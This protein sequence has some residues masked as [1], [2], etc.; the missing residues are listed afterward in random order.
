[1]DRLGEQVD[2]LKRVERISEALFALADGDNYWG[3]RI[4]GHGERA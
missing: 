2:W 1:M 4:N 3:T